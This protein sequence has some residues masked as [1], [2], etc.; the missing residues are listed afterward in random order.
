MTIPKCSHSH[1]QQCLVNFVTWNQ[2]AYS[3]HCPT[4]GAS[5][6]KLL[7]IYERAYCLKKNIPPE[8]G[9]VVLSDV[10]M[11]KTRQRN[12]EPVVTPS[13]NTGDSTTKPGS[14]A[15]QNQEKA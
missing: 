10:P 1:H 11:A 15:K 5:F 3:V 4:C 9:D 13:S 6:W 7:K 14:T 12:K 8:F 2:D